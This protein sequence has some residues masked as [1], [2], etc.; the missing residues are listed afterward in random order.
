MLGMVALMACLS[1]LPDAESIPTI[2]LDEACTVELQNGSAWVRILEE[3][4]VFLRVSADPAVSLT[5]FDTSEEVLAQA[6]SGR[7]LVLSAYGDYWFYIRINGQA[8]GSV[9]VSAAEE[10][11]SRLSSN[12][13][14]TG[15]LSLEKMGQSYRFIVPSDGMWKFDLRSGGT[16]DLDLEV[17]GPGMSLWAGGYSLEPSES[18]SC[19][20]QLGDT[21]MI[22][23]ARYSKGGT[24]D[25]SLSVSRVGGF[26]SLSGSVTGVFD[27]GTPVARFGIPPQDGWALLRLASTSED[28]DID[29]YVRGP[30]G[31]VL[32]SSSSY[33][34]FETL[35]LPPGRR[36]LVAEARAYDFGDSD[37][38]RYQLGLT[39]DIPVIEGPS[40]DTLV[41]LSNERPFVAGFAPGPE[42]LFSLS[43]EFEKLRDGDLAVFRGEGPASATMG[44]ARGDESFVL[45]MASGDT[46][47]MCPTFGSIASSGDVHLTADGFQGHDLPGSGQGSLS[48]DRPVSVWSF[49][50][51]EDAIVSVRLRGEERETDLDLFVSGPGIDRAAQGGMSNADAAGDEEAAFYCRTPSTFGITVYTYERRGE[52]SFTLAAQS[53]PRTSLAPGSSASETWALLAGISGYPSS[54]DA[55]NRAGMDA[56]DFYRFLTETLGIPPDH[57]VLLV[58]EMATSG[59]FEDAVGSLLERAGSGDRM[60]VFFSGH[61]NQLNPGSGGSEE[62]DSMNESLCL[63][64]EEIED[65][66]LSSALS[67]SGAAVLL[68]ADACFSGG[69]VN[70]FE[71]GSGVMVLTAAREDRSVSERILTPILLEGARGAADG[72]GNGILSARELLEYVD[73]ELQLICPVC[74]A[75]IDPVSAICPDCGS[76]LKGENRVPRPE[77]G[78]FLD[79][80]VDLWAVPSGRT[81]DAG[82]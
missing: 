13:P 31:E 23:V 71:P 28:G 64:D 49:R 24:G 67:G 39:G 80:D 35:L 33:S 32:W 58:D 12:V 11:P 75:R 70:D 50:S 45:W 1:T 19:A 60:I 57:I 4:Y 20:A 7:D 26:P 46:L 65:D 53:I 18:A 5:A 8:G 68:F 43:A 62:G 15:S 54:T 29:L 16:M 51:G 3:D 52:G 55:L 81:R 77:Q 78:F 82:K 41:E 79:S 44:S 27:A 37:R 40:L 17:Y 47:W 30:D 66:W 61:G 6:A 73:A 14:G 38:L 72:N 2:G 56:L 34:A 22:L 69:L 74:D 59:A 76:V 21:L 42:G 63:Y 9:T 10:P 25:Y 36:G 48:P